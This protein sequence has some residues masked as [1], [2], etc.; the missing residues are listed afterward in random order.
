[1][2]PQTWAAYLLCRQAMSLIIAVTTA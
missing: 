2:T 1:L